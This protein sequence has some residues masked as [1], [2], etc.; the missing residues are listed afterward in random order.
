MISWFFYQENISL[1]TVTAPIANAAT[2]VTL[3]TV[4]DTPACL[5]AFQSIGW[6]IDRMQ[7]LKKIITF[8]FSLNVLHYTPYLRVAPII[9]LN[10]CSA[11]P[12]VLRNTSQPNEK[13]SISQKYWKVKRRT[14]KHTWVKTSVK[15]VEMWKEEHTNILDVVEALHDDEHVVDANAEAEK[16]EY[17]VHRGVPIT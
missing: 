11:F 12:W 15:I 7:F 3:V 13:R 10:P 2:S 1:P 6:M 9:W 16:G 8:N 14:Y 17:G 5:K 4:R